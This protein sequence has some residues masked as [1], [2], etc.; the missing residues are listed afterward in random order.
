[1]ILHYKNRHYKLA[2]LEG[3]YLTTIKPSTSG[4]IE[5][6]LCAL[7][8]GRRVESFMS[9][10]GIKFTVTHNGAEISPEDVISLLTLIERENNKEST[11]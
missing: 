11:K 9:K 6:I 7:Q 3:F 5:S 1:M 10:T 2:L 4:A 8:D